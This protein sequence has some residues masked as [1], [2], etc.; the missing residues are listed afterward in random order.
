MPSVTVVIPLY[1]K[2]TYVRRAVDSVLAQTFTDFEVIVV[3]DGSTD[4]GPALVRQYNDPRVRLIDQ[5]NRGVSAA[6]NRGI[7]EAGGELIAF[8]DAD[9]EW[10]PAYLEVVCHLREKYP[11]AG[12]Y[13][14]A[15]LIRDACGNQR[16]AG[17]RGVPSAEDWEGV[18]ANYFRAARLGEPPVTSSS[19]CIP[20]H[21]F[22]DIGGFPEGVTYGE[23]LDTWTRI[24]GKYPVAISNVR[25]VIYHGDDPGRATCC[26]RVKGTAF[27]FARWTSYDINPLLVE[28]FHAYR[29]R[30]LYWA[31]KD[32]VLAG[33]RAYARRCLAHA[34]G[35]ECRMRRFLVLSC[36]FLPT[37]IATACY[38]VRRRRARAVRSRALCLAPP[39]PGLF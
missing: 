26:P 11:E 6:R 1:N 32:A 37:R 29:A 35:S 22:L 2:E 15:Y 10:R 38:G 23:D 18:V 9:D 25:A 4:N 19:A 36:C 3:N 21:V 8:L 17:I 12:M 14:T 20:R 34:Q 7:A 13:A 33:N 16:G 5:E 31:A 28:D 27:H 30:C 39:S 24:A